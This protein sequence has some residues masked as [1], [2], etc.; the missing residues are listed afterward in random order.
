MRDFIEMA[1]V[2]LFS[3]ECSM[4]GGVIGLIYNIDSFC[5]DVI[6]INILF[7]AYLWA[8]ANLEIKQEVKSI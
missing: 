3:F 2:S 7:V 5:L 6:C 8:A 1:T 4:L